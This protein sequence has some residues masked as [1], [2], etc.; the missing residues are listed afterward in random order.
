MEEFEQIETCPGCNARID[1]VNEVMV[2]LGGVIWC[3]PC[4]QVE[5][6]EQEN[7]G[8]IKEHENQ[9]NIITSPA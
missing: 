6:F 8:R 5:S 1:C 3:I 4:G 2:N 7:Q 9:R